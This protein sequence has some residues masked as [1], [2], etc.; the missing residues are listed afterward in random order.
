MPAPQL[1]KIVSGGQ[2]GADQGALIAA[3]AA[4]IETGGWAPKGWR[5]EDGPA[6]WLADFG[7]IECPEPGYRART[8]ANVRDSHFTLW[9]GMPGTPGHVAT[10]GACRALGR[11]FLEV[12]AGFTRPRHV[13]EWLA[14]YPSLDVLNCAGNRESLDPGI[15]DW[16]G[17]FLTR[18]FRS[19]ERDCQL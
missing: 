10:I 11:P 13:V 19:L 5:T 8:G 17:A 14:T 4:G 15:G 9:F 2:T 7:L 1:V 3:S 12:E 6:P 18:V 16:V